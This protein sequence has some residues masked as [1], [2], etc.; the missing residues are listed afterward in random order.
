[1][2]KVIR[3]MKPT[4]SRLQKLATP[5]VDTPASVI[6]KLLDFYENHHHEGK[7]PEV[8]TEPSC[9]RPKDKFYSFGATSGL[10]YR[11]PRQKGVVIKIDGQ[12]FNAYSLPELYSQVLKYLCDS[13]AIDKIK[14]HLP[15]ATSGKRYL[16]ATEPIHPNGREFFSP[17]EYAGFYM[18]VHKS[19]SC[20][21]SHLK[22]LLDLCNLSLT[23]ID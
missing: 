14:D 10:A 9:G 20:G 3:I 5:L 21:I 18:E 11:E 4:F 22:K 23:Y 16:I 8:K 1:M 7:S 17:I 12:R 13:G 6:D 15:L 19:Y 2:S